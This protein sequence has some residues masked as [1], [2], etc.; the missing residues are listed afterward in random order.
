MQRRDSGAAPGGGAAAG[1][2][3]QDDAEEDL[4]ALDRK[5]QA[6]RAACRMPQ[7]SHTPLSSSFYSGAAPALCRS[8]PMIPMMLTQHTI[9]RISKCRACVAYEHCCC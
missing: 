3:E 7:G 1:G 8:V 2:A 4:D 5:Q 6:V 9:V